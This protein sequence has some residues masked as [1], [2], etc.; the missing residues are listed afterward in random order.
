MKAIVVMDQA[1]GT[2][3]MKLV[4][5]PEPQGASLASRSGANPAIHYGVMDGAGPSSKRTHRISKVRRITRRIASL[6]TSL[7]KQTIGFAPRAIPF[8][9]RGKGDVPIGGTASPV[10]IRFVPV[11]G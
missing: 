10:G 1:A 8:S 3:G 6:A 2:A 9:I 7:Q 11:K 4:E 5:R